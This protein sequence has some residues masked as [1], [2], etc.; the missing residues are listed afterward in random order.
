MHSKYT[1]QQEE[2]ALKEFKHTGSIRATIQKLGYPSPATLYRWYEHQKAGIKN[3]HGFAGP[4]EDCSNKPHSCNASDHP[5]HPSTDIKMDALHRCFELG[6]DVEYVSRDIGYSR[7]SIYKW[8]RLYLEKGVAGLM[9]SKKN[10]KRESLAS[11]SIPE[12]LTSETTVEFQKKINKL[13]MEVDILKETINVL[14]KDPGADMT[15]L[16]NREKAVAVSALKETYALP[17]LLHELDLPRSS[18]FY[19]ISAMSQP[20]KYANLR[21]RIKEIFRESRNCYGYRRIWKKLQNQGVIISEKIVRRLM[22]EEALMVCFVNKRKYN[23]YQGEISPEVENVIA[24]DFHSETPNT[25]WLT[26]ITEFAL[27]TGKVY[28]S[29]MLDCFDGLVVDWT[30]GTS[31]KAELVN[32]MLDTAI[33]RLKKGEMPVIHTDRGCHYRWRGWI[34]RMDRAGLTRSMSKKGCSPD[35]SACEGF[36]GRLKNEMFYGKTW[37]GVSIEHFIEQLNNYIGWYNE[38]RIKISLGGMSPVEYRRS[39]G[40]ST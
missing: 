18:Y 37:L 24:R 20:D 19:Q 23:S 34:E 29:P 13:Q 36:F 16:S 12:P 11:N 32:N 7:C 2:T 31:P 33:S 30:I 25:K 26:D 9:S 35:N 5:R 1:N 38:K 6:E 15:N 8:R 10:I 39:I 21:T 14:K 28:L 4:Y 22:K 40:L 27:P 17:L 3:R